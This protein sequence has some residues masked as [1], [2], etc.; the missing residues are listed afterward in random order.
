M[1]GLSHGGVVTR[2]AEAR[3]KEGTKATIR[4]IPLEGQPGGKGRCIVCGNEADK[5]VYFGRAY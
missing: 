4:C 5:K 2:P 1:D 3:V